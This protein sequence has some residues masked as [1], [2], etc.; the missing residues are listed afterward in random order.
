VTYGR[1]QKE[2]L[3]CQLTPDDIGR[4][5][6]ERKHLESLLK[7][8]ISFLLLFAP[9]LVAA[10]YSINDRYLKA[11]VLTVGNLIV[12]L[13]GFGIWRT[14]ML[15]NEALKDIRSYSHQPY[16]RYCQTVSFPWNANWTLLFVPVIFFLMFGYLA[17][18]VWTAPIPRYN[19]SCHSVSF[20]TCR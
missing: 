9:V 3:R 19:A 17:F 6:V 13:L 4:A 2:K 15:V 20:Y 8:R 11:I 12:L 16:T 14:T 18:R 5:D 7:D 1:R 10:A